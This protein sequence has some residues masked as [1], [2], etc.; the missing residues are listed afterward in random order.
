MEAVTDQA[1]RLGDGGGLGSRDRFLVHAHGSRSWVGLS[2][3]ISDGNV[4]RMRETTSRWRAEMCELIYDRDKG[5]ERRF[6][7]FNYNKYDESSMLLCVSR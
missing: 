1:V 2:L 4:G 6:V 7:L 5:F 3:F